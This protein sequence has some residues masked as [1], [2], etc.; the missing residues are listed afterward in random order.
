MGMCDQVWDQGG[1]EA[2]WSD[3][4]RFRKA[5]LE[6]GAVNVRT[7]KAGWHKRIHRNYNAATKRSR[8]TDEVELN[9]EAVDKVHSA[10]KSVVLKR[11]AATIAVPM[12]GS[13]SSR[14]ADE[15]AIAQSHSSV[16]TDG[17]GPSDTEQ[18]SSDDA[19]EP[20]AG[21]MS[22][23]KGY[24]NAPKASAKAKSKSMP[25]QSVRNKTSTPSQPVAANPA[26]LKNPIGSLDSGK[27]KKRKA[28]CQPDNVPTHTST[29]AASVPMSDEMCDADK[30]ICD[31]FCERLKALRVVNPPLS[32]PQ[33][34]TYIN[35]VLSKCNTFLND[36]KTKRRSAQRRSNKDDLLTANLDSMADEMQQHI[37]ILKCVIGTSAVDSTTNLVALIDDATTLHGCTFNNAITRK[38]LKSLI[39]QDVQLSAW[40]HMTTE[41]FAKIAD[42]FGP[43]S[44]DGVTSADFF[45]MMMTQTFQK[46]TKLAASKIK[47]KAKCKQL[48]LVKDLCI[49]VSTNKE[50]LKHFGIENMKMKQDLVKAYSLDSV[51]YFTQHQAQ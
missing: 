26:S 18:C 41:T 37:H 38:A 32:D 20:T 25:K 22:V 35:D 5:V 39:V 7:G 42:R 4:T 21:L 49:K 30:E 31:S 13:S 50:R 14:F 40:K 47:H 8:L 44:D 33:F 48:A 28:E 24:T 19:E 17:Q 27:Q 36:V 23:L 1:F 3:Q 43:T 2:E 46:L 9:E 11:K 45:I 29:P 16:A 51:V 6:N 10:A 15:P 34:K 12:F